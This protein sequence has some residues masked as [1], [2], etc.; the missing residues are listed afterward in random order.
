MWHYA[1]E[2]L[3]NHSSLLDDN[4]E[5]LSWMRRSIGWDWTNRSLSGSPWHNYYTK[6][7][8]C[9]WVFAVAGFF[10]PVLSDNHRPCRS[11]N[12]S[13]NSASFGMR[14]LCVWQT[15]TS[16]R[17]H[18]VKRVHMLGMTAVFK[19][20]LFGSWS[21]KEMPQELTQ[22]PHVDAVQRGGPLRACTLFSSSCCR[23]GYSVF[24]SHQAFANSG[25]KCNRW[26]HNFFF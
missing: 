23:E 3:K 8:G 20:S 11:V 24:S 1:T 2:A 18:T 17:S 22:A 26:K 6:S 5:G 4:D 7:V 25:L 21:L 16:Q 19:T 12:S 13:P 14:P 15:W 10:L 9:S